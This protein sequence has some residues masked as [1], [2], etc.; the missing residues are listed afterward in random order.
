MLSV[1]LWDFDAAGGSFGRE[2]GEALSAAAGAGLGEMSDMF[3]TFL[4]VRVGRLGYDMVLCYR[5]QRLREN[6]S[7]SPAWWYSFGV[8]TVREE[9][10]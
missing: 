1:W 2:A 9:R 7:R 5:R 6:M 10:L 8:V 3:D 4:G